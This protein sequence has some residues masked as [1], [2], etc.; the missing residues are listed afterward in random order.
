MN[1]KTQDN[2]K[3]Q[4]THLRFA[5][6]CTAFAALLFTCIFFVYQLIVPKFFYDNDWPTTS[7]YCGFYQLERLLCQRPGDSPR[8]PGICQPVHHC[9]GAA[10]GPDSVGSF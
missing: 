5:L 7:T 4:Q 9:G 8:I 6:T 3:G 10:C 2:K 1:Q